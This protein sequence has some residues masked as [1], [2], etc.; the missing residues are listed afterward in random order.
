M[1]SSPNLPCRGLRERVKMAVVQLGLA[2]MK[3]S[4]FIRRFCSSTIAACS[5]FTSG[6]K[7]GTNGSILCEDAFE[8]TGIP[9]L[10]KSSSTGPAISAGRAENA[11]SG[12]SSACGLGSVST[13]SPSSS[14]RV[15]SLLSPI[16]DAYSLPTFLSDAATALTSN[17]GCWAISWTNFWPIIPVAPRTATF[18]LM[19]I[20]VVLQR[21]S[22]QVTRLFPD[23]PVHKDEDR[24]WYGEDAEYV[25]VARAQRIAYS[26]DDSRRLFQADPFDRDEGHS[27]PRGKR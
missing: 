24:G 20:L 4:V 2:T 18:L 25:D 6:F 7:R 15:A 23:L 26:C 12:S 14:G 10:A 16:E 5:G 19:A 3:P 17:H 1:V 27:H 13:S 11:R 8:K 22:D 9:A 21:G